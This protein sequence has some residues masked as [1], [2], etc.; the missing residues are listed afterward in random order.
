MGDIAL[1]QGTGKRVG[2]LISSHVITL[3]GEETNVMSLGADSDSE[4]DLCLD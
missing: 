3:L 1:N 4:A 2:I